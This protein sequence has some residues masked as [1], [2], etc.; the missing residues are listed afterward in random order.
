MTGHE[1]QWADAIG[2]YLLK[3]LPA[4]EA[5]AFETHL[6]GC[7][8]C[9]EEVAFLQVAADAL[10]ASP[11]Q[12][13]PP[14]E[15]KSRIMAVVSAEASLLQAAGARAD[16]PE[17]QPPPRRRRLAVL[18]PDWWSLRPGLALASALAVLV[19]GGVGGA[20]LTG[21][22]GSRTVQAALVPAGADAHLI[23]R[24]DHSTL[25]AD[26]LPGPGQGRVYQVW[27]K[28]AGEDPQPTSALFDV[29]TDGTASVDV[30]GDLSDVEA[31]LVTSE[32]DGGSMRPTRDPLLAVEPA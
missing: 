12:Y 25:V 16:E 20:V 19:L 13:E 28:R 30:P 22:D 17:G 31:V 1:D 8:A 3:A 14:P 15:L 6:A 7:E 9:R 26:G 4:D 5:E 29:R 2:A 23:V 27:L 10:P 11:E 32:P 18:R 24:D 21:G